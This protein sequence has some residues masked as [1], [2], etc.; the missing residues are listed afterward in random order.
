ML[1]GNLLGR[2]FDN[3]I[4][5]FIFSE[6]GN[7]KEGSE[8][9]NCLHVADSC[10]E[11]RLE[12]VRSR[13]FPNCISRIHNDVVYPTRECAKS[14]AKEI[15]RITGHVYY[16]KVEVSG[17]YC[18]YDGEWFLDCYKNR[19]GLSLFFNK[20]ARNYWNG[21]EKPRKIHQGYL[22]EIFVDG[23]IRVVR[24]I[25]KDFEVCQETII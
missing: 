25:E 20:A 17:K 18:C 4:D 1:E 19:D 15:F 9:E 10:V 24:R 2:V 5:A 21:A 3:K 23:V 6:K 22:H 14:W 12:I 11:K 16:Y 13:F 7:L 8:I